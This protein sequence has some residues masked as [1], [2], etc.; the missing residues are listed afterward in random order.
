VEAARRAS[1]SVSNAQAAADIC[2]RAASQHGSAPSVNTATRLKT[3]DH[4]IVTFAGG[5][6]VYRKGSNGACT[7]PL[8]GGFGVSG[9]GVDEDDT[10]AKIAITTAGFCYTR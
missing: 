8:I 3:V 5:Q 4:G 2:H 10:V 9:D 7:G 1:P 6:P